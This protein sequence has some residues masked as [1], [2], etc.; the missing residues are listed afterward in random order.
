MQMTKLLRFSHFCDY[1]LI[2]YF[3]GGVRSWGGIGNMRKPSSM[4]IVKLFLSFFVGRTRL[5]LPV[6][7]LEFGGVGKNFKG[8]L[9][10]T[11]TLGLRK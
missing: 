2:K 3:H 8:S 9:L 11:M 10:K 4:V 1:A 6:G 5:P 7:G